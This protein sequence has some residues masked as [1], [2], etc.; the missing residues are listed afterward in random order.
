[1]RD[2]FEHRE[3]ATPQS[4]GEGLMKLGFARATVNNF[5]RLARAGQ[6]LR[7]ARPGRL[8]TSTLRAPS[9]AIAVR[10]TSGLLFARLVNIRIN[11]GNWRPT[12]API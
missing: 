1:M 10:R 9:G 11:H 5:W 7:P 4:G 8:W 6:A 2:K 12:F 3:S